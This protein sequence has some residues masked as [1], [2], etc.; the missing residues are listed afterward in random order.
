MRL[1]AL[2]MRQWRCFEECELEFPDGLTG[3]RGVNG[4][5][6]STIAEA[7]G[8]ALFGKL[9]HRREMAQNRTQ[10]P[11]RSRPPIREAV[12]SNSIS[13]M[14]GAGVNSWDE[15]RRSEQTAD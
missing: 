10:L 1:V 6:K 11:A 9:R 5:G 4:A 13:G 2:R 7:I 15:L 8:W 3:I 14:P 12:S